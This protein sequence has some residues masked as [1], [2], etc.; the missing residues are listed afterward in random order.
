MK[1]I[2]EIRIE[3]DQIDSEMRRLFEARMALIVEVK[4]YKKANN[5]PILDQNREQFM[6]KHHISQL[7]N[8]ELESYYKTFLETL[9]H[10]SKAY[11]L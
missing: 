4:A 9:M 7:E 8:K 11:Q 10:I 6:L 1:T 2:E 3:L 5:L